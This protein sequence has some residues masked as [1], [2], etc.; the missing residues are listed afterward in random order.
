MGKQKK[1][2]VNLF[3][4]WHMNER[5]CNFLFRLNLFG[6]LNNMSKIGPN[7]SFFFCS[8]EDGIRTSTETV[9][10]AENQN[11]SKRES[12]ATS[13]GDRTPTS[14]E[15][16]RKSER[17][18]Q[19]TRWRR[20]LKHILVQCWFIILQINFIIYLS[21]TNLSSEVQSPI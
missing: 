18:F 8:T 19:R 15:Q 6:W 21:L 4:S 10:S 11:S 3:C 16:S 7:K 20:N 2:S 5:P 1:K 14:V 9:S 17:L 13:H 12:D